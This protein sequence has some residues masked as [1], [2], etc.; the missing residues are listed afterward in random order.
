M[1]RLFCSSVFSLFLLQVLRKVV[2]MKLFHVLREKT[3]AVVERD[4]LC[5]W[6]QE[7]KCSAAVIEKKKKVLLCDDLLVNEQ[8]TET[9]QLLYSAN[10]WQLVVIKKE[11]KK[12]KKEHLLSCIL[13]TKAGLDICF[14]TLPGSTNIVTLFF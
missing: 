11:R 7:C 5:R 3:L 6:T 1:S 4:S 9:E 12:K 8:E 10:Q 14:W 2:R 13:H